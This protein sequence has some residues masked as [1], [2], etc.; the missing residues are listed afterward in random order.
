M[1]E[2]V[3]DET[4][5]ESTPEKNDKPQQE[6]TSPVDAALQFEKLKQYVDLSIARAIDGVLKKPQENKEEQ[7][8][9]EPKKWEE[10]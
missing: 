3:K 7:K 4:K 10:W 9:E 6:A 2:E 5:T 1:A 8:Q